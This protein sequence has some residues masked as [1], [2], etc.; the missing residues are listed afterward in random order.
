MS[1]SGESGWEKMEIQS[2]TVQLGGG[3]SQK[4][5]KCANPAVVSLSQNIYVSGIQE[6]IINGGTAQEY[7]VSQ[8]IIQECNQI[9]KTS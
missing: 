2:H 4:Q 1:L 3:S 5:K 7:K 6:K 8:N 9:I